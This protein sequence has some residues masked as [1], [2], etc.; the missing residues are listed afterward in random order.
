[1]KKSSKKASKPA[2]ATKTVKKTA[3]KSTVKRLTKKVVAK[4]PVA[5]KVTS[6][7]EVQ[8]DSQYDMVLNHIMK[9]GSIN[10]MEAIKMG[11]LRLGA[12]VYNIRQG[13]VKVETAVHTFK[14]KNGRK[15]NVAK[16]ILN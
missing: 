12:V 7:K 4:K 11:V 13:G 14:N 16:Y 8:V 3:T 10:T 1:M 15:S 6:K 2:R 9:N 5:K